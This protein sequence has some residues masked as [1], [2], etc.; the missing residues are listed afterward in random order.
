VRRR[1]VVLG[2][3]VAGLLGALALPWGGAGGHT[4]TTSAPAGAAVAHHA[5]YVVRPG[6][7]LWS[8]AE[9]LDPSGDPRPVVAQ[10]AAEV[11]SDTVVPGE[12]VVLP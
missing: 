11:G 2:T 9:R 7:T 8:I 3:V 6:D 5:G 12:H 10:L 4:I 1:R